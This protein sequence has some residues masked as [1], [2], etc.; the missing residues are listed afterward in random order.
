[1]WTHDTQCL[2][3]VPAAERFCHTPS[4]AQK[5]ASPSEVATPMAASTAECKLIHSDVERRWTE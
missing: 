4:A 1:M 3:A 2:L 5:R